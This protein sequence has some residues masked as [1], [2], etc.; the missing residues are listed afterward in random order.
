M[1]RL[2]MCFL[3]S[4]LLIAMTACGNKTVKK[5]VTDKLNNSVFMGDSIT[6]GFAINEILPK[7]R[8]IAGAGA[9][10]G[11][12]YEKVGDLIKKKPDNVFI[13]L[14]SDDILMPVDNPKELFRNDLTKLINKIKKEL[15]NSKIY[16][17]SI[18]PVTKEVLKKESRYK[19]I[20]QY[21][22]LLKELANKL[23][24]NYIDIGELVKKNPNLYAED[25]VH[26]KKEFYN[27][28]LDSLSK[29]M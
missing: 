22:E 13:M 28:W 9:T 7:E 1:K 8:V 3:A 27:L 23:S 14:G 18:T 26:F 19:N 12:S 6:E 10:A 16:I 17:Q 25:G 20:N 11:F 24:V 2:M 29:S 15:P 5:D 21:N 4:I